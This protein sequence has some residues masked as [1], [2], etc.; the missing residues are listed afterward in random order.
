MNREIGSGATARTYSDV[1]AGAGIGQLLEPH[2]QSL[3]ERAP[4]APGET[5]DHP[6][7]TVRLRPHCLCLYCLGLFTLAFAA[8]LFKRAQAGGSHVFPP[9]SDPVVREEVAAATSLTR[10]RCCQPDPGQGKANHHGAERGYHDDWPAR[11]PAFQPSCPG[12]RS[13][14]YTMKTGL[15]L[16][17]ASLNR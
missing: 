4:P 17:V 9:V 7:S 16:G 10:R 13:G 1:N 3:S 5:D 6:L 2:A 11:P 12:Q 14:L 15:A 8:Q